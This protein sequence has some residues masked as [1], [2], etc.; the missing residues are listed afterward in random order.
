MQNKN[1]MLPLDNDKT[2]YESAVRLVRHL[3]SI[4]QI[5]GPPATEKQ[6]REYWNTLK[7]SEESEK[8]SEELSPE[9]QKGLEN[10]LRKT[11]QLID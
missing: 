1:T 8:P 6:L 5:K 9:G 3:E 10:Y 2:R 11:G 7:E 4:G